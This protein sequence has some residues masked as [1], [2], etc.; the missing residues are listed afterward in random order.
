M[1]RR[2]YL[3]VGTMKSATSYLQ[4]LCTAN[5]QRLAEAG[6]L[7]PGTAKGFAAVHDLLETNRRDEDSVGAW[8]DLDE[9]IRAFDGDVL[10]SNELILHRDV[11]TVSTLLRA[12]EPAEVQIVVTA[13][14]LTRVVPSQ[15]QTMVRGRGTTP[16]ADYIGG[17]CSRRPNAVARRVWARQDV[18]AAVKRFRRLLPLESITLVTV[19]PSGSDPGLTGERFMSVL[20]RDLGELAAPRYSNTSLGVH[21]AE[22][23]RRL[24]EQTRD[25]SWPLYREAFKSV[26]STQVLESRA[27]VEPRLSLTP[28]QFAFLERRAHRMVAELEESGARVVG[29]LADLLP[30]GKPSADAVDPAQSTADDLLAAASHGLVEL[31]RR[32]GEQRLGERAESREKRPRQRR[33]RG[34]RGPGRGSAA[35]R[36]RGSL[37]PEPDQEAEV[38]PFDDLDPSAVDV[39]ARADG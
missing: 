2:V 20:D 33:R 8:A 35:A 26:L 22:L 11:K 4:S 7:Y 14:D 36:E 18:P 31:A 24:N 39:A 38:E 19:P 5:R 3:H 29:D 17:V 27:G 15:W 6:V 32:I 13:R 12:L 10:I 37:E 9:E 25:W 16:W 21:S 30:R 34:R 23:V 1:A 28:E